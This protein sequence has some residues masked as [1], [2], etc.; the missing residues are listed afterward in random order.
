MAASSSLNDARRL[1]ELRDL[2]ILDTPP[3]P[4]YDDL[5]ALAAAVCGTRFAA[6]NFVDDKRHFTKAVVG[7]PEAEGGSISNE[8]SF[9]AATLVTAEGVLVVPDTHADARFSERCSQHGT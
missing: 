4:D 1:G 2:A 5:A 9:C 3:E 6:V 8:Q 7:M